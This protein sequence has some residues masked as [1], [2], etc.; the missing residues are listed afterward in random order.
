[1]PE[2]WRRFKQH[3]ELMFSGPLREKG[4]QD[5]CSYLLLWVGEKGRDIYNAKKLKTYYDMYTSYLTPKS[6]PIY[7]RYRFHE[8]M[9]GEKETFERFITELKL[10][11][12]DCGYPN[13]DELVRGRITPHV[14]AKSCSAMARTSRWRRL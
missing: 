4:E 6:N 7:A 14:C 3:A 11:V 1:M 9:Q 13:S 12:R 2:A 8:K 5:K 10:L